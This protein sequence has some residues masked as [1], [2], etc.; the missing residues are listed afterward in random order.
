[1]AD[2]TKQNAIIV[3]LSAKFEEDDTK[4]EIHK[5]INQIEKDFN[6]IDLNKLL[7]NKK[8]L[9]NFDKSSLNIS[10]KLQNT[11]LKSKQDTSYIN[12]LNKQ[13]ELYN[14]TSLQSY[15]LLEKQI[16]SLIKSDKTLTPTTALN[17]YNNYLT[18]QKLFQEQ[19]KT[20]RDKNIISKDL[21]KEERL[22]KY[23]KLYKELLKLANSYSEK[24]LKLNITESLKKQSLN[25]FFNYQ[26]RLSTFESI[27]QN[28][29]QEKEQNLFNRI[30]EARTQEEL[31][32]ISVN[33]KLNKLLNNHLKIKK[34][35]LKE[36]EK[37]EEEQIKR[38]RSI[39]FLQLIG[40]NLTDYEKTKIK[41]QIKTTELGYLEKDFLQVEK[42]TDEYKRLKAKIIEV[43]DEIN[44]LNEELAK[45]KKIGYFEKMFNTFK[46]VGFYRIAR[47]FFSYI[48]QG[49][50]DSLRS[51]TLFDSG[52]NDT[53]SSIS[54]SFQ[55]LSSSVMVIVK[56]ALEILQPIISSITKGIAA[57]AE[58]ISYLIAKLKGSSEYLKINTEYMK[59]FNQ[60]SNLFSFD[61]F[62]ALQS[63]SNIDPANM[64]IE[65]SI[66]NVS[67]TTENIAT[68][69]STITV[70][71][72]TLA[73]MKVVDFILSGKHIEL[74]TSTISFFD[75]LK[76][77]VSDLVSLFMVIYGVISTIKSVID[78]IQGW[79][80]MSALERVTA[81]LKTIVTLLATAL[82]ISGLITK[83]PVQLIGGG[84]VI[85]GFA[86][87]LFDKIGLFANG[88]LPTKG[89]LFIAN[90]K[91]PEIVTSLSGGQ[92]SVTNIAQW[93]EAMVRALYRCS[94]L[95]ESRDITVVTPI[96]GA[97]IARSKR[98]IDE[99]NRRN[100]GIKI[101]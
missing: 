84:L 3:P 73:G 68:L 91:G 47:R 64:W 95:F 93:E 8:T 12:T 61:K 59:D 58:A 17:N 18:N 13:K 53:M 54:S 97:E 7:F 45:G 66:E 67:K 99:F 22:Q 48:E 43:Q 88:G 101:L 52:F 77:K 82:I 39:E 60:Q 71:L 63:T 94:E 20:T 49:F 74:F 98:F 46:R 57:M 25:P 62:E 40:R 36:L 14:L 89:D 65:E 35:N 31:D 83:N 11:I 76:L 80:D 2:E 16:K 51:L 85:G 33:N 38:D 6:K 30:Q 69:I 79:K 72:T 86:T 41:K 32:S 90:E 26:K 81:I 29:Q 27:A 37:Q 34:K 70:F 19:I 21:Q 96:D 75:K 92:S 56:P 44:K 15:N 100:S 28:L 87:G 10:K 4:E 24:Q 78:L 23:I 9:S 55:I 5:I 42:D 50:G 1:M